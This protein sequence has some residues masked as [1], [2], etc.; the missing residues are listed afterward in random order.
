MALKGTNDD[1]KTRGLQNE[2]KIVLSIRKNNMEQHDV[3][4]Y[5]KK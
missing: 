5:D 4:K 1:R 2:S 3:R